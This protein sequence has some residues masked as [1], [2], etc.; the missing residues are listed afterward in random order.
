MTPSFSIVFVNAKEKIFFIIS[1]F[2]NSYTVTTL[3]YQVFFILYV[4]IG[5]SLILV[6]RK[7]SKSMP[8]Q[9]PF[10]FFC[11]KQKKHVVSYHIV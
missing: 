8:L 4:V 3:V 5:T 2:I 9:N 7:T 11:E 10:L 6:S 1:I